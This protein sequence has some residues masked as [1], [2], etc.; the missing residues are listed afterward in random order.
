MAVVFPVSNIYLI[1][2]TV[3]KYKYFLYNIN[4]YVTTILNT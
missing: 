2:P 4:I 3:G 1:V